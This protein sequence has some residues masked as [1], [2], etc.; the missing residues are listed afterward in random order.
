MVAFPDTKDVRADA[1][2]LAAAVAQLKNDVK[3]L[4]ASIMELGRDGLQAAQKGGAKQLG[5]W[6]EDVDDLATSLKNQG[7]RQ[8]AVVE[9]QMH[10]RPL[11]SLV[12][13]FGAGLLVS[14]F[15]HRR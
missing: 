8:L 15:I 7:R 10:E 5:A 9:E 11:L 4:S 13:A 6:R 12:A 3:K 14:R 1:S 2:E